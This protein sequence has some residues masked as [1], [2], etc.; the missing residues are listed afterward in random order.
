MGELHDECI[1]RLIPHGGA[2]V[3]LDSILDWDEA[4][5]RLA[6]ATHRDPRNP[7][8]VGG[9]LRAFNLIEYGALAAAVHG[10]LLG[11][12]R[13]GAARSG[14]LAAVRNVRLASAHIDD[15][16]ADLEIRAY[17]LR[18]ASEGVLYRFEAGCDGALLAS[19][20]LLIAFYDAP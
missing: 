2:M 8:S 11:Q 15:I 17:R 20:R 5:I 1:A 3:L 13:G 9:R 10:G 7:L 16:A 19:G 14:L 12:R 4:A 18:S 6:T